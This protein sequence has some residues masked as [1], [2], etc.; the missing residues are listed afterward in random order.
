[1]ATAGSRTAVELKLDVSIE[2]RGV[3]W[4]RVSG[5]TGIGVKV[6]GTGA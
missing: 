2:G 4:V 1:M 5:M 3:V 6:F